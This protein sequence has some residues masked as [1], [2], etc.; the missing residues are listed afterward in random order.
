METLG[1]GHILGLTSRC[2][3]FTLS[4]YVVRQ[5]CTFKHRRHVVTL[6]EVDLTQTDT[7]FLA[8]EVDAH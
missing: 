8:P 5:M 4:D 7:G 3:H 1:N 2:N 6:E